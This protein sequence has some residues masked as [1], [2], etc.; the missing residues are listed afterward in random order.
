MADSA[1]ST[2]SKRQKTRTL[3]CNDQD[4]ISRLPDGILSHILSFLPTKYAALTR[5]LSNRWQSVWASVPNLDF[6]DSHLFNPDSQNPCPE[7]CFVNFVTR[8]LLLRNNVSCSIHTFRLTCWHG[9][10]YD[11][12]LLNSWV[13]S[14]IANGVREL[15]LRYRRLEWDQP[16]ELPRSLLRCEKL[17]V[18]TLHSNFCIRFPD[19]ICLLSLRVLLAAI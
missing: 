15:H 8:V 11:R 1:S 18:L 4:R 6:D 3:R 10:E 14:A 16:V 9:Y 17:E 7:I 13:C 5:I 2:S 19:S 12:S